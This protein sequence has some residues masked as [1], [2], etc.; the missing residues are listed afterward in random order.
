MNTHVA[1]CLHQFRAVRLNVHKYSVISSLLHWCFL[2]SSAPGVQIVKL[3]HI[4]SLPAHLLC[5][6]QKDF[7]KN[8]EQKLSLWV[9]LSTTPVPCVSAGPFQQTHT[10]RSWWLV[11]YDDRLVDMNQWERKQCSPFSFVCPL[12][13]QTSSF[14]IVNK[15]Q[16]ETVC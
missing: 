3:S 14:Y 13:R 10:Y 5:I 8:I 7:E 6:L 15:L 12:V 11:K 2:R 16:S 9:S 1:T 4:F